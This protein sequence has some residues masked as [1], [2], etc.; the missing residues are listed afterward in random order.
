[1]RLKALQDICAGT[2]M[3]L[4]ALASWLVIF[5]AA[6]VAPQGVDIR[7]LSPDFWPNVIMLMGG[8]GGLA[9]ALQGI[10]AYRKISQEQAQAGQGFSCQSVAPPQE[11]PTGRAYFRV[12]IAIVSL[13]IVYY[14][15]PLI[16]M[17]L[18]TTLLL[19]FLPWFA[20][21]NRWRLILV[22]A[23][24]LPLIL[25]AFFVY[26]ANIPIPQGFFEELF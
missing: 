14:L 8:L 4:L 1:M 13:L 6:I 5:P 11:L 21:E 25:Y 19:L 15:I 7:A 17:V 12:A 24:P 3:I 18:A 16:G 10:I 2:F 9:L 22:T 20:G 26:V 23:I